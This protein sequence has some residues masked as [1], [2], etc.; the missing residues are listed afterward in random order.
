MLEYAIGCSLVAF[1]ILGGMF[2]AAYAL[3]WKL[4][5]NPALALVLMF[6][7]S[8]ISLALSIVIATAFGV[9]L[10]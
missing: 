6:L 2:G 8:I 1:V 10:S 3:I 7:V 9:P 5:E 4:D